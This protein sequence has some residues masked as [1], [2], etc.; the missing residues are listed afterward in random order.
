MAVHDAGRGVAM[1]KHPVVTAGG[2]PTDRTDVGTRVG[3]SA[4]GWHTC[5][6]S[7]QPRGSRPSRLHSSVLAPALM[8]SNPIDALADP[9]NRLV[10]LLKTRCV[11]EVEVRILSANVRIHFMSSLGRPEG[12]RY[13]RSC[14]LRYKEA[15]AC[16]TDDGGPEGPPY[17]SFPWTHRPMNL[18]TYGLFD[19]CLW[20]ALVAGQIR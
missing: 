17:C 2:G 15:A 14:S 5:L 16:A 13:G 19:R 18:S 7:D 11:M 9:L 20:L 3:V 1:T 6:P 4:A 12:L 8:S 10:D